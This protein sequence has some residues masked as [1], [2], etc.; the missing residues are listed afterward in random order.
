[1]Y[2]FWETGFPSLGQGH[3]IV[4]HRVVLYGELVASACT[5]EQWCVMLR[6][7]CAARYPVWF[8]FR[9]V[10]GCPLCGHGHAFIVLFCALMRSLTVVLFKRSARAIRVSI[11][12]SF[13]WRLAGHCVG[14][15][16]ACKHVYI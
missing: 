10:I 16:A 2:I 1:M 15:V 13:R 11:R 9:N 14:S 6:R 12:R 3:V 5:V 4:C 7:Q 8:R